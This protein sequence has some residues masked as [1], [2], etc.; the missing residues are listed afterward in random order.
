MVSL[1]EDLIDTKAAAR[2]LGVHPATISRYLRSGKLRGWR[3]AGCRARISKKDVLALLCP[4]EPRQDRYEKACEELR[5][6]GV[7]W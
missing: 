3:I 5:A 4:T 1:P 2:L 7:R 6:K